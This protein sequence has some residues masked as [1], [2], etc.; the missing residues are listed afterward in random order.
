MAGISMPSIPVAALYGIKIRPNPSLYDVIYK[1]SFLKPNFQDNRISASLIS[2]LDLLQK[3]FGDH[4]WKNVV[5]EA[6]HWSYDRRNIDK[7][8]A[9][10]GKM[11]EEW[12]SDEFNSLF[13]KQF[14][15]KGDVRVPAVFIDTY[16]DHDNPFE[17]QKFEE[18]V[19]SLLDFSRF[20][21]IP[22]NP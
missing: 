18:N 15:L 12:W 13:S 5:L 22:L 19:K 17:V 4:F 6:T 2:M 14:G 21:S 16:F 1:R 3:M 11:T 9:T 7:R 8:N 10:G 20:V